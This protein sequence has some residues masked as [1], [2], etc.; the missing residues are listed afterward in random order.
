MI[1]FEFF[2]L[3]R[4][5]NKGG[6]KLDI[7][8]KFFVTQFLI[9]RAGIF[10]QH[11]YIHA[12][13]YSTNKLVGKDFIIWCDLKGYWNKKQWMEKMNMQMKS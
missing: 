13:V 1:Q 10:S 11:I 6:R 12:S 4:Y 3:V 8:N 9:T 5:W 2:F 7:G